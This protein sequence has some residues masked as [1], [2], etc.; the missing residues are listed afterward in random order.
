MSDQKQ[1]ANSRVSS[2]VTIALILFPIILMIVIGAIN[3]N[4]ANTGISGNPTLTCDQTLNFCYNTANTGCQAVTCQFTAL[5]FLSQASPFT[6]ILSG[7]I[8]GLFNSL[9]SQANG[10]NNAGAFDVWGGGTFFTGDCYAKSISGGSTTIN[11]INFTSCTET[12]LDNTNMSLTNP[13]ITKWL[14]WNPKG[15]GVNKSLTFFHL[16]TNSTHWLKCGNGQVG[17][18][19]HFQD[20][21]NINYTAGGNTNFL[22]W[23]WFGCDFF[24]KATQTYVGGCG[25]GN[26]ATFCFTP[27]G[28]VWSFLMAV[29]ITGGSSPQATPSHYKA[30]IEVM[31]WDTEHCGSV[32]LKQGSV[33]LQNNFFSTQCQTGMTNIGNI[34][35]PS[36]QYGWLT[37]ILLF[38]LGIALVLIGTGTF[39]NAGGNVLGTGTSFG[40]GS[41]PQGTKLAQVIGLGLIVWTVIFSEFGTW[42]NP[43]YFPF[44][45]DVITT[46]ALTGSFFF[47]LY[48]RL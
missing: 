21:A 18:S 17:D 29:Q 35:S 11:R 46:F 19:T 47:G 36:I 8:F 37:P 20:L 31:N 25:G 9:N 14:N 32:F 6:Q 15:A 16:T 1:G 22:G 27:T 43:T 2:K 38:V 34:L 41:N 39:F 44:G 28:M 13:S 30:Y 7:N 5:S 4:F 33:A 45:L 24:V 42:I 48:E 10:N 3:N 23:S 26:F 12:N 40:A